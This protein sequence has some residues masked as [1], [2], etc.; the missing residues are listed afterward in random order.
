MW[1]LLGSKTLSLPHLKTKIINKDFLQYF[2]ILLDSWNILI[3]NSEQSAILDYSGYACYVTSG[4]TEIFYFDSQW[5]IWAQNS[6]LTATSNLELNTNILNNFWS[7]LG[8]LE[9]ILSGYLG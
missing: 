7:L 8:H 3:E 9:V 5:S 2:H 6:F 4:V 1:A